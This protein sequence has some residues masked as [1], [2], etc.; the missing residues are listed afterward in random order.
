MPK[1]RAQI[2]AQGQFEDPSLFGEPPSKGK[3]RRGGEKYRGKKKVSA[4]LAERTEFG[5]LLR[6]DQPLSR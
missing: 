2:L 3:K 5:G 4:S 6:R 1:R